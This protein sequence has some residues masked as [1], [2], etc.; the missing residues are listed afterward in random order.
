MY[1]SKLKLA[2][3]ALILCSTFLCRGQGWPPMCVHPLDPYLYA[4]LSFGVER[5]GGNS[6]WHYAHYY[7]EGTYSPEMWYTSAA[8][9]AKNGDSVLGTD[10]DSG[11]GLYNV[12]LGVFSTPSSDGPGAYNTRRQVHSEC[13]DFYGDYYVD[14]DWAQL[15][16]GFPIQRP[17][18]TS[19][20]QNLWYFNGA[21]PWLSSYPVSG[22]YQAESNCPTCSPPT[23]VDASGHFT[24]PSSPTTSAL[25]TT[26]GASGCDNQASRLR[27]SLEGFDSEDYVVNTRV[28]ASMAWEGRNHQ[29]HGT[30]YWSWWTYR[31]RDY[32]GDTMGGLPVNERFPYSHVKDDPNS[33]WPTPIEQYANTLADGRFS[34][35]VGADGPYTPAPQN[36]QTPL[37]SHRIMHGFQEFRAGHAA[38]GSGTYLLTVTQQFFRDHGEHQ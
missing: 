25:I 4:T 11:W 9:E 37:G 12:L 10:W 6:V 16:S 29:A 19:G 27:V 7:L 35:I 36:P 3:V 13:H 26:R 15:P 17:A 38:P 28:P 34:D 23:W 21:D 20:P 5:T 33:S 31:I 24:V 22:V 1:P 8:L 14:A 32:C 2:S 18:I 30:G